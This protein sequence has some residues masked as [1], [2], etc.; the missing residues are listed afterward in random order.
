MWLRHKRSLYPK[1]TFKR[2]W[3]PY[4]Q[5]PAHVSAL[6]TACLGTAQGSLACQVSRGSLRASEAV[7]WL[8]LH[9]SGVRSTA[10][11]IYSPLWLNC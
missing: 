5:P 3:A 11:T 1:G 10:Q 8:S 7:L 9:F 2:L 4:A 6:Y